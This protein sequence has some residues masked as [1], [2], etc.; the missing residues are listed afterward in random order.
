M[1]Q[2]FQSCL[3]QT[4]SNSTKVCCDV[5]IE[6]C[7]K[8]HTITAAIFSQKQRERIWNLTSVITVVQFK[9][10]LTAYSQQYWSSTQ[11]HS[12]TTP[13]GCVQAKHFYTFIHSRRPSLSSADMN[14]MH[15][16]ILSARAPGLDSCILSRCSTRG[17]KKTRG[18]C[19]G[20]RGRWV[21]LCICFSL[22]SVFRKESPT[23]GPFALTGHTRGG[24][25]GSGFNSLLA[26][27]WGHWQLQQVA[28]GAWWKASTCCRAPVTLGNDTPPRIP[29]MAFSPPTAER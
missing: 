22:P 17:G 13:A 9:W 21:I 20:Y 16:R 6:N 11:W 12:R 14:G 7:D 23:S 4:K 29:L 8:F 27:Q 28:G 15:T 10:R 18:Q 26:N 5:K 1:Q 25:S 19:R 24:G 2:E 3:R